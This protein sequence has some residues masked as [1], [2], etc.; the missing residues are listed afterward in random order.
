MK[1]EIFNRAEAVRAIEELT[2]GYGQDISYKASIHAEGD[3]EMAFSEVADS[4]YLQAQG[5]EMG[6]PS[7]FGENQVSL[8]IRLSDFA[9]EVKDLA[10]AEK[11]LRERGYS[12]YARI[13]AT[14]SGQEPEEALDRLESKEVDP[15]LLLDD[16]ENIE[17]RISYNDE[18]EAFDIEVEETERS[19]PNEADQLENDVRK[20]LAGF[21]L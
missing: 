17:T 4:G 8:D 20:A 21:N 3:T 5:E 16:Y 7:M 13:S 10:E 6:I 11:E 15:A 14:A 1:I 19:T 18:Q 2:E 12:P 9:F